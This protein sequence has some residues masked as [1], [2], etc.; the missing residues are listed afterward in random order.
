MSV[1]T[2]TLGSDTTAP[3]DGLISLREAVAM[4]RASAGPDTIRF[5]EGLMRIE[6]ND[7]ALEIAAGENLT[8][9]GDRNGDGIGDV[10][11]DGELNHHFTVLS[12]AT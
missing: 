11:L 5:A 2:V 10:Y 3:G 6:I 9:V 12:G 4:A 7:E 1:I 8:I